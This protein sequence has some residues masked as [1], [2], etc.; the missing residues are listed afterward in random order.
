MQSLPDKG[1]KII[2]TVKRL[3]DLISQREKL[4]LQDMDAQFEKLT[5]SQPVQKTRVDLL[6]SDDSDDNDRML[7]GSDHQDTANVNKQS[8]G[9]Q[10]EEAMDSKSSSGRT[11]DYKSA[12]T[13]ATYKFEVTG[14]LCLHLLHWDQHVFKRQLCTG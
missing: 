7:S 14:R 11:W 3:K 6:D 4:E 9:S 2:E 1:K 5:V 13:P 12:A 8:S 10:H